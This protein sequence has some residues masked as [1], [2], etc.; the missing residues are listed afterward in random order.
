MRT[1]CYL[2]SL[3]TGASE[4]P[5]DWGACHEHILAHSLANLHATQQLAMNKKD[6]N[7]EWTCEK[8]I[9]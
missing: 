8:L 4:V 7:S 9:S 5:D 3:M 2:N 6:Y 1:L